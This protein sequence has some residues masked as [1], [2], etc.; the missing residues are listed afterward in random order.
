[1]ES[2]VAT[3][4]S[5]D[6]RRD[7]TRR[8]S[9]PSSVLRAG[10]YMLL[11]LC[12]IVAINL[13]FGV[14]ADIR[15]KF[16]LQVSGYPVKLLLLFFYF[17]IAVNSQA[18]TRAAFRSRRRS[19]VLA[20]RTLLWA[21]ALTIMVIFFSQ[22]GLM[23][24]RL[25]LATAIALSGLLIAF[26]RIA[27]LTLFVSPRS[28]FWERCVLINDGG[29]VV[30]GFIGDVVDAKGAMLS[31][32]LSDPKM[33]AKLG[34]Y[35]SVYDSI[36]ISCPD[37]ERQARW[38]YMLKFYDIRGE[39]LLD[40]GTPIAA[41][42][43]GRIGLHDTLVVT[44]GTLSLANRVQK[45]AFDLIVGTLILLLLLP[46][47]LIVASAIQMESKGPVL[48]RQQRVGYHNRTFRIFKFCSMRAAASDHAGTKSTTPDDDR[49]TRVGRFIRRTSIDELPQLLNVL[50]G[51]MSLVGPRPHALGSLVDDKLFW[52]VDAKYFQR[53]SLKPGMTG[54]AQVRGF[55]GATR[56]RSDLVNRLRADIEYLDGWTLS[57]DLRTLLATASV[58]VHPNAF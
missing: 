19:V 6:R 39:I 17:L 1:M 41:I 7:L 25:A 21:S 26:G 46:V 11:L 50:L 13:A 12:D 52:E 3:N 55:R 57:R 53:H 27:I 45:R 20:A 40:Q 29:T 18:I 2:A 16:W 30:D 51:N 31:P 47:M 42:G 43:I 23:L 28:E 15:G 32:Q 44:R 37:P 9:L 14:A 8:A 36:V 35:A 4:I 5:Q 49:I 34:E 56:E 24:S 33:V 48:F 54:L 10:C 38:S 22:A 58:L